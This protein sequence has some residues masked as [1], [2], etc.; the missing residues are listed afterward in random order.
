LADGSWDSLAFTPTYSN[1]AFAQNPL[2]AEVSANADFNGDGDVDGRDFLAWQR[3]HGILT[4]ALPENG[5][6]NGDGAV[7]S[8]DLACWSEQYGTNPNDLLAFTGGAL[9]SVSLVVPEPST[10]S[11]FC[12]AVGGWSAYLFRFRLT[13]RPGD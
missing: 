7:D 4:E 3:G 6:A 10:L 8:A 5:D 12:L 11:C 2:A 13:T 9:Q 1:Q